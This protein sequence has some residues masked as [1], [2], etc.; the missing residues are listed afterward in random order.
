M[1]PGWPVSSS[2]RGHPDGGPEVVPYQRG[3]GEVPEKSLRKKEER[4]GEGRRDV[5]GGGGCYKSDR[6]KDGTPTKTG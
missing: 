3:A 1:S 2:D 4:E 6:E 5:R